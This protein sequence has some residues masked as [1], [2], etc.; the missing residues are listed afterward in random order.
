VQRTAETLGFEIDLKGPVAPAAAADFL[1]KELAS[2][3]KIIKEIG[4]KPQ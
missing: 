1:R 4:I 2:S 3:G